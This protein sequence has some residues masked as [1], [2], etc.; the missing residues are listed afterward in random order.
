MVIIRLPLPYIIQTR[1]VFKEHTLY[2]FVGNRK[3]R[4]QYKR[5]ITERNPE[6]FNGNFDVE[7]VLQPMEH[8]NRWWHKH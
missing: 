5:I 7:F 8:Q 6:I 1:N 3:Q 4:I 2:L